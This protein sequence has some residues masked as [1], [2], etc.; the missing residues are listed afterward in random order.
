MG[1]SNFK[2]PIGLLKRMLFSGNKTA[3]SV[4]FRE[5]LIKILVP[6]EPASSIAGSAKNWKSPKSLQSIRYYWF[7][8]GREM[9]LP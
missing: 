3:Y 6:I 9:V 1:Y 4:L 5:A 8:G 2:D 7:W